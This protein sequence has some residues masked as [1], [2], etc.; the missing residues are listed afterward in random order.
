EVDGGDILGTSLRRISRTAHLGPLADPVG[1]LSPVDGLYL[2]ELAWQQSFADGKVVVLAGILDQPNYLDANA[3]AHDQ[4]A[5]LFNVGFINSMVLPLTTGGLGVN[6]QWQPNDDYYLMFGAGQNNPVP[7]H[8][9]LH[10]LGADDMSYLFEA[11]YVPDNLFGLGPGA[12]RLQP[13]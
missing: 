13:F 1:L 5:Q 10:N 7:G 11:G 6:L 4:F 9:P 12:Y 2:G 3:Y 8:S